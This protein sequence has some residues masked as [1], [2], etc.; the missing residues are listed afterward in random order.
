MLNSTLCATG[1]GICCILENYQ[2][3]TGVKVP[4]V[5]QKYMGGVDFLPFIRDSMGAT[6]GEV[7]K[8]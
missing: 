4:E 8:K 6:K 7:K 5:L 2:T 3:E 1:R